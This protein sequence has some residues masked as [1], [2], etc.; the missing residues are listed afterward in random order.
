MRILVVEDDPTIAQLIETI[1][2]QHKYAVDLA[3][4]GKMGL[5]LSIAY[6]YDAILLDITLPKQDGVSV[7]QEIRRKG[8]T[9]PIL[10]MIIWVSLSIQKSYW[11][12]FGQFCGAVTSSRCQF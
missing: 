9:V 4:D 11:P 10:L 8:N 3:I 2:Q 1:L 6:E 7:C 12:E 5:E